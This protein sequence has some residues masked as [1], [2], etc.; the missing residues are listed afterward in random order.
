MKSLPKLNN[1]LLTATFL[2]ALSACS[3]KPVVQDY[4][5][6]TNAGEEVTNLENDMKTAQS[7]QVDV[8]SPHNF[9]EANDA[10]VDAKKSHAKGKDPDKTLR[11]V[12]IGRAYLNNANTVAETARTNIEDVI[13]ARQ[14]AVTAGAPSYFG[15]EMSKADED[16]KDVT[17]DI[18]KNK[19]GSVAKERKELQERYLALELKAIKEKNIGEA[20]KTIALAEKEK[21]EKFAPTTLAAAKKSYMDTEAYITA[22]PH[23]TVAIE[24]RAAETNEAA[25]HALNVNRTAKGTDK[26]S[27]EEKVLALEKEQQRVAASQ[28]QLTNVKGEL[29]NTQGQLENTQGQLENTQSAL[30]GSVDANAALLSSQ[31]KLEADK[32]LNEKYETARKEFDPSEAEVYKQGDS[33]LIRLKGMAFPS[34][35]STITPKGKSLLEKVSKVTEDF[36]AQSTVQIQGHTDSVG[37][38][39]INDKL[40]QNRADAVKKY[41]Q[42]NEGG[43]AVDSTKIEAMGYGYQKPLATN[44]T[45]DGRA[46]NRRVDIIIRP[47]TARE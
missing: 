19:M 31:S 43:I 26:V 3:S 1:I 32:R 45:A 6:G 35:K 13:A 41:L 9:H 14:A 33:L 22:N 40:S 25:K 17:E 4:P 38:K 42:S 39:K 15:K 23:N 20:R 37:G 11:E 7:N 18:E 46:Q 36:G 24:S 12:A 21:A 5:A 27:S 29:A 30:D 2:A 16:F 8:L 47:D 34:A 44:K 28:N 10:L